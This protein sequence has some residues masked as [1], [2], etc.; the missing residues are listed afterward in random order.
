MPSDEG[1]TDCPPGGHRPSYWA[2]RVN[3][4][5]GVSRTLPQPTSGSREKFR[6][7][8]EQG[9]AAPRSNQVMSPLGVQQSGQLPL[10]A[11]AVGAGSGATEGVAEGGGQVAAAYDADLR[12]AEPAC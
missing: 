7:Y 8:G 10:G 5:P 4:P 1:S 6:Y 3:P 9:R 2:E 12:E 11:L